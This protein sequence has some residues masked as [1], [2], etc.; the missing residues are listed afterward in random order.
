VSGITLSHRLQYL[1]L[2]FLAGL[3]NLL[4][5]GAA[6]GAGSLLGRICWSVLGIRRDVSRMNIRQAFPDMPSREVDRVGRDSYRN[7]GRAMVEFARQPGMDR[8][9]AR[10]YVAVE[11][12]PALKSFRDCPT[13]ALV[14]S[15]HFGNWEY[16][17]IMSGFLKQGT[18]FLVGRQRN[19]LVDGYINRLRGAHGNRLLSRDAAMRGIVEIARNGGAACWLSDQDAGRSGLVVPFFGYPASTPRGA[20]AFSVKL[21]IPVCCSFMVRTR[22]PRQKYIMKAVLYPRTDLSRDDAELD[23]TRRYTE[24]LEEAVRENPDHYW[25]PHRR[26]KT[27]GF[28]RKNRPEPEA[29]AEGGSG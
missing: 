12:T 4:P 13:G 24:V 16:C 15:F 27:T 10:K 26:W 1:A 5:P 28:Y 11:E 9:Y 17:G 22:G 2:L 7:A 20:A 18:A 29:P 8:S 25:W 21:G 19:P 23:I 3:L 6:L 14:I